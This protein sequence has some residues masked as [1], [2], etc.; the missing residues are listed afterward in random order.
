MFWSTRHIYLQIQGDVILATD[1]DKPQIIHNRCAGLKHPRM[2][3][4]D[5]FAVEK[6]F[7]KI[8]SELVPRRFLI[9]MPKTVVYIH[10]KGDIEGG[11]TWVEARAF[12]EA[13]FSGGAYQCYVPRAR[14]TLPAEQ[15]K[16]KNFESWD[17]E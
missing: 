14:D 11:V 17:D 1:L 7:K 3:M 2:L 10:L 5:F 13:A 8:I 6:C 4:G 16:N 9:L 15:L 12:K